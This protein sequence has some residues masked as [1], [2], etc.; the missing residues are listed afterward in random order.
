MPDQTVIQELLSSTVRPGSSFYYSSLPLT[1]SD[2][3][4]L[5]IVFS[6]F[7]EWL[8]LHYRHTEP[9]LKHKNLQWWL[10]QLETI[11]CNDHAES[12]SADSKLHP[13]LLRLSTSLKNNAQRQTIG[14][15]LQSIIGTILNDKHHY[16]DPEQLDSFLRNTWG[17]FCVTISACLAPDPASMDTSTAIQEQIGV[18][19]GYYNL[20]KQLAVQLQ[21]G[22][23]P[24]PLS[25]LSD[26]ALPPRQLL[27]VLGDDSDPDNVHLRSDLLAR[28]CSHI[29]EQHRTLGSL[30]RIRPEALTTLDKLPP[31][32]ALRIEVARLKLTLKNGFR[33]T[34]YRIQLSPLRKLWISWRCRH[35]YKARRIDR[36]LA[37]D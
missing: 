34:K 28:I 19:I 18:C 31:L 5:A 37:H 3:Q 21:S 17:S 20:I 36:L 33:I 14:R 27:S 29:R 11:S 12:Q 30:V 2:K 24:L 7:T 35:H 13:L 4:T 23:C 10:L 26:H 25:W 1:E 15:R 22:Y 9:E 32:I 16:E 6:L 8:S